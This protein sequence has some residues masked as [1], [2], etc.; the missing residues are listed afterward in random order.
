MLRD[1][2]ERVRCHMAAVKI[3]DEY[4][5]KV[6]DANDKEFQEISDILKRHKTLLDAKSNLEEKVRDL[7]KQAEDQR[8]EQDFIR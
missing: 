7:Q 6:K 4:L 5:N 1:K 8:I 2:D 3:Y